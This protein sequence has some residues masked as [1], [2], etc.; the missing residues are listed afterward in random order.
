MY[1]QITR[2]P[3]IPLGINIEGGTDTQQKYI[4]ISSIVP[5]SPADLSGE[6]KRGDQLQMCGNE[7]LIGATS[8]EAWDILDRAP[9]TVE[10]VVARKSESLSQL[11]TINTE[12]PTH[13][14][15]RSSSQ[16][17]VNKTLKRRYSFSLHYTD[18]LETPPTSELSAPAAFIVSTESILE[19]ATPSP[20]LHSKPELQEEEFVVVINR[21]NGQRLGFTVQGGA[22]NLNL[23]HPHVSK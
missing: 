8:I 17:S 18:V 16:E 1:L 7:C 23:P 19:K 3:G 15:S 5:N 12:T 9:P 13:T 22:D 2:D 11:R 6:L 20:V 10:I 4:Y 14:V 21:S